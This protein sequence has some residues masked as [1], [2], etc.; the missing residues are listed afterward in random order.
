MGLLIVRISAPRREQKLSYIQIAIFTLLAAGLLA[1]LIHTATI[2]K[3][4]SHFAFEEPPADPFAN[5]TIDCALL[6]SFNLDV[7]LDQDSKQV[8]GR[9][10]I[11]LPITDTLL[12]LTL[13]LNSGLQVLQ[14]EATPP[15]TKVELLED[16]FTLN[17]PAESIG[18]TAS[19]TINYSGDIRIPSL[20]L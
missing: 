4:E 11:E 10:I 3:K 20:P 9:A 8:S 18:T 12:Q 5:E 2:F 14:V 6:N 1:G 15:E 13:G 7:L 19:L 16:G 17:F